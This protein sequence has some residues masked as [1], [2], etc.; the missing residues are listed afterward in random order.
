MANA[1]KWKVARTAAWSMPTLAA[2]PSAI[3]VDHPGGLVKPRI[4]EGETLLRQRLPSPSAATRALP[5][6]Q[7][8]RLQLRRTACSSGPCPPLEDVVTARSGL[9]GTS[10]LHSPKPHGARSATDNAET[11]TTTVAADMKH[12]T[13]MASLRRLA[14]AAAHMSKLAMEWILRQPWNG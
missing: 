5:P 2:R 6:R 7:P 9:G 3:N 4:S 12:R 10:S 1:G 13:L 11:K 14:V 8:A